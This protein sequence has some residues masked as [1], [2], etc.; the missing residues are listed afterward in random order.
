MYSREYLSD[1]YY[2]SPGNNNRAGIYMPQPAPTA[3]RTGIGPELV[4]DP[5]IRPGLQNV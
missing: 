3:P 1:V 5:V 4:P 2:L